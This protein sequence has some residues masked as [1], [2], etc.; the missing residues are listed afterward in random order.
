MMSTV[1]IRFLIVWGILNLILLSVEWR[2]WQR[3]K[4]AHWSWLGYTEH[5]MW[6]LTYLVLALD[7]VFLAL[8]ILGPIVYWIIQPAI[9]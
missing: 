2:R 5:F 4:K 6:D 1:L 7:A 8:S 9:N 3:A